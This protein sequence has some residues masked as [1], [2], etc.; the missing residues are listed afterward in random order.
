MQIFWENSKLIE[1]IY[2]CHSLNEKDG[3]CKRF[4]IFNLLHAIQ[5]YFLKEIN[6]FLGDIYSE[7][8]R[9]Y[10]DDLSNNIVE[11]YAFLTYKHEEKK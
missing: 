4:D 5:E 1:H 3:I 9:K 10:L 8:F 6:K 11:S 2:S 7:Q